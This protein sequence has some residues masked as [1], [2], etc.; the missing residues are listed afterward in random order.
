MERFGKPCEDVCGGL[1]LRCGD[2]GPE[3]SRP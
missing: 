3:Q 1:E 2:D